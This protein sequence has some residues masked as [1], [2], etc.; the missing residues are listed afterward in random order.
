MAKKEGGLAELTKAC[1]EILRVS[2]EYSYLWDDNE[3]WKRDEEDK[4][5]EKELGI[6]CGSIAQDE[7]FHIYIRKEGNGFV[8]DGKNFCDNDKGYEARKAARVI[9]NGFSGFNMTADSL[10]EGFYDSLKKVLGRY[11]AK[12]GLEKIK[13]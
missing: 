11:L 13:F 10:K 3:I 9:K 12:K 1:S 5:P 2:K 4:Y 6:A 8:F 7:M